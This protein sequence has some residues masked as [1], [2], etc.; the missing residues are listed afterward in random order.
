[1]FDYLEGG[2]ED[3]ITL[4]ENVS[5]FD[6]WR[7]V[8]SRLNNVNEIESETTIFDKKISFPGIIAP[9]GLSSLFW[10]KGDV[11][12]AKAAKRTGIPFI[13]STASSDS[14]EKVA[15][16]A[17]GELWFQLYVIERSLAKNLVGRAL[18]A[19][20]ECLVIT[21]D[22]VVNGKRERDIRN[23][24]KLPF[25]YRLKTLFDGALHPGWS[26]SYLRNGMPRLA[27]IESEESKTPEAE[28]ALLSRSMDATF[29]WDDLGWVRSIWPKKLIIKGVL[30]KGDVQKCIEYGV[31]GVV[32]SNHGGR[33][34]DGAELPMNVLSDLPEGDR[35]IS[36]MIDGGVRR[37]RD[38]IK[39]KSLGADAVLLGRSVAYG[40][41]ANGE[42]GAVDAINVLKEEFSCCLSQ[43]GC[44]SS[45]KLDV[46]HVSRRF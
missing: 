29:N 9:V 40:L 2:A 34:I 17:G 37:G 31:D 45:S 21:T 30:S 38:I 33:Q 28:A 8:P 3:E 26:V 27:N 22:V 19:G 39:A 44:S 10:P 20:Y 18:S 25:E 11:A 16:E 35:K 42:E 23:G 36:I 12:L 6:G 7:L 15:E 41:A 32:I 46:E 13:L 1:M 43:L 14:I 24:F 5:S 4:D